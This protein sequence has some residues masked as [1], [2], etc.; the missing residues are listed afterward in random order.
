MDLGRGPTL[1]VTLSGHRAEDHDPIALSKYLVDSDPKSASRQL[2]AAAKELQY[3]V[4][5]LVVA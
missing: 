1:A 4:V 3:T 2:L 5:A